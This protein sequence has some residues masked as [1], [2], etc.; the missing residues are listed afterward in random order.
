MKTIGWLRAWLRAYWDFAAAGA[1]FACWPVY[2][3][4]QWIPFMAA[5]IVLSAVAL[6][7]VLTSRERVEGLFLRPIR[8]RRR[9]RWGVNHPAVRAKR[10]IQMLDQWWDL[11]AAEDVRKEQGQ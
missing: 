1:G 6:A 5:A 11:P 3:E 8:R 2:A 10:E 4:T 7:T 9:A